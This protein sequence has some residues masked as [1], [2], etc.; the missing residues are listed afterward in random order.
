[1]E[2]T[3]DNLA[4]P[5]YADVLQAAARLKGHANLTPLIEC[6]ALNDQLEGRLLFK[7]ELFQKTGS[8]KFRGAY[9]FIA[10]LSKPVRLGGVVAFSSG[11]HA[12]AVALA[13]R[14]FGIP[15]TIVMPH[16]APRMKMENT[17][18]YGATVVQYNRITQDR[19]AIA[20]KLC[21][22]QGA[23][24]LPPFDHPW[25]IAGQGTVGLELIQQTETMGAVLDSVLV[26][27]SGGGLTAGCAL[28]LQALSPQTQVYTVE[29]VGYDDTARSLA[30]GH[31]V[32]I[33]P[34]VNSLCD[35]LLLPHPG[36]LT[37]EINAERV[38]GGLVVTDDEV[39]YAMRMAFEH[40]K[41]V[42]EPGG[43]VGLAAALAGKVDCTGK[44]VGIILSGGNVDAGT[45]ARAIAPRQLEEAN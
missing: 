40:L 21:E 11:N 23:T 39:R 42:V 27:C 43:S 1:M 44:T 41:L 29:P 10:Q 16:D 13:A 20:R 14:Q 5:T 34:T 25:T 6:Q 45:Y 35:A 15:A 4:P 38:A 17:R 12:Q 26:P 22:E 3:P 18:V 28:A 2:L 24:L 37:F 36:E 32:S 19:E 33:M 7:A 8:F 9:N 31:P 30:V